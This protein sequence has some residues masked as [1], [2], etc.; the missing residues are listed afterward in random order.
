MKTVFAALAA[1]TLSAESAAAA[2]VNFDLT[3]NNP[4]GPT[5]TLTEGSTSMV[6]T[7][8]G[9]NIARTNNGFGVTGAP[10]GGRLGL[11]ESLTFDFGGKT[12]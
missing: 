8:T 9:G 5:F 3:G 7:S 10:E 12:T 4:N 1:L 6:V 2:V 11:G